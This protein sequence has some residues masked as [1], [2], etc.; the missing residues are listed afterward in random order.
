MSE[1]RLGEGVSELVS[2]RVGVRLHPT[3]VRLEG[4]DAASTRWI[5]EAYHLTGDVKRHLASVKH[6]LGSRRGAGMFLVGQYGAGKSHFLAY[7]GRELSAGRLLPDPPG[8][9]ALSLL[10]YRAETPL[11]DIVCGALGIAASPGDRRVAWGEAA[12]RWPRGLL[13]ILDELSEFLRSKGDARRL[14]EDVRFL[15]FLGEWAQDQ[16]LWILGA[17]QEEVEHVGGL[18]HGLYR[19]IKDRYPIKLLLT[20][21]HVKDLLAGSILIKK[22]GYDEAVGNLVRDLRASFRGAS[23][24]WEDLLEIYPIH[25][26]TL[27]LLEEV[28]DRFS[29]ARGV[30]DFT[31]TQ[32]H[33]D[34]ARGAAPFL[35]KPWGSLLGPDAIVDHFADLFELSPELS[36][37]AQQVLPYYRKNLDQLFDLPALR[38]LAMRVLKLLILV[39]ISPARKVLTAEQAASYLLFRVSRLEPEKNLQTVEKVLERL[40]SQG[41]HVERSGEGYRLLVDDEGGANLEHFL[42]RQKSELNGAGPV[43][44]ERLAHLLRPEEFHPFAGE[45]D[46]WQSRAVKWRFHERRYALY[47]GNDA[48]P[49]HEGIGFR[50]RLPWGEGQSAPGLYTVEPTPIEL[51]PEHVE[52]AA[53]LKARERPW[54]EATTLRLAARIEERRAVFRAQVQNAYLGG[55]LVAPGGG[56]EVIARGERTGSFGAWADGIAL[57]ILRRTYPSFEQFAPAC[58]PLPRESIREL[59]RHAL[60]DTA[61]Q[62][63]PD[64]VRVIQDAY[65]QPMGLLRRTSKGYEVVE[66]PDRNELVRLVLQLL[67]YQPSP[68]TVCEHLAQPVYGLVPDQAA[69]LLVFLFLL[70]EIDILKDRKSY[71]ELYETMPNPLQYDRI[72]AGTALRA[73]EIGPFETLLTGLQLRVPKMWTVLAQRQ[74]LGRLQE[75]LARRAEPLQQLL[76]K[77]EQSGEGPELADRLRSWLRLVR[78]LIDPDVT[79]ESLQEFLSQAGS[80]RRVLKTLSELE[81]LPSRL[82]HLLRERERFRHLFQAAAQAG[83][84]EAELELRVRAVSDPPGVDQPEALEVWLRRAGETYEG[85]RTAYSSRHEAFWRK[86]HEDPGR[87]WKPPGVARSR[88]LG[89]GPVLAELEAAQARINRDACRSL[90][91]LD[92]QARCT[93]GF[94]GGSHPLTGE[95]ERAGALRARIESE[96]GD[97]FRRPDVQKR[98][99]TWAREGVDPAES[100]RAFLSGREPFPAVSNLEAFD[101]HLAGVTVVANLPVESLLD[102][103]EGQVLDLP[104]LKAEIEKVARELGGERFRLVAGT[105]PRAVQG[106]VAAPWAAW[107]A[108][109]ALRGGVPLPAGLGTQDLGAISTAARLEWIGP[110]SL[111][112]LERLGF[113]STFVDRVVEGALSGALALPVGAGLSPLL[114]AVGE[115]LRPTRPTSPGELARLSAR[116][117]AQHG[118]LARTCGKVWLERLETLATT[119]EGPLPPA[120]GSALRSGNEAQWVVLDAAGLAFLPALEGALES[121]FPHWKAA[122]IRF[123][124][125]GEPTTTEEF[126]RSLAADGVQRSIEKLNAL[127]RLLHERF[128]PFEDLTRI[129]LAE[130][131]AA[132][133][134]LLKRLDPARPVLVLAD[135]GF[136]IAPDGQSYVHGGDSLLERIVP[137]I[138]LAPP[139]GR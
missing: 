5:T 129:A 123:A 98:V 51:G 33:G 7:L 27:D 75:E 102:R 54:P 68:R 93:C 106:S 114:S 90:S 48:P 73:E 32:L 39:H 41:R 56:R 83:W 137:L 35:E 16:P 63:S 19:K 118:R 99:A 52:L 29:L 15:Q 115:A 69:L 79:V 130:L 72:V 49:P 87:T 86:V 2:G 11:E 119:L 43:V 138:E 10:N 109:Q 21:T 70:G 34:P 17:V 45:R 47:V 59:V 66:R 126:F 26:A 8:T 85:Y 4:L 97:F 127:D 6:A 136:R 50:V 74:A 131:Q 135:H 133:R 104:G 18:D 81:G 84:L 37:I 92:F 105:A 42:E 60:S 76:W 38:A 46:A 14:N 94:D 22:E 103:L 95:L 40:V 100:S 13:L 139:G 116:L 58:G 1:S 121:L 65:L 111:A 57:V 36:P 30:V 71:R 67:E 110:R 61:D 9:V 3:V 77:L 23:V 128:L 82:D 12:S 53:L 108:E 20:T 31:V 25:P 28:R 55:T 44:L 24:R 62:S 89:L 107:C 125:V 101:R 80:A 132:A 112:H 64:A 78:P 122:T 124:L 134:A 117:Y 88:H 113:E 96:L 120:L 91:N